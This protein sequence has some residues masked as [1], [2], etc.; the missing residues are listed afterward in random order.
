MAHWGPEDKLIR[1]FTKA[2]KKWGDNNANQQFCHK[3]WNKTRA[4][5]RAGKEPLSAVNVLDWRFGA[6]C[7]LRD[8]KFPTFCVV[9]INVCIY[10]KLAFDEEWVWRQ[11]GNCDSYQEFYYLTGRVEWVNPGFKERMYKQYGEW[12]EQISRDPV[13]SMATLS[14]NE[15]A[16]MRKMEDLADWIEKLKYDSERATILSERRKRERESKPKKTLREFTANL[17]GYS[18][19]LPDIE[20]VQKRGTRHVKFYEPS[21]KTAVSPDRRQSADDGRQPGKPNP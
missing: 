13:A 6:E 20:E 10:S 2:L 18:A 19:P 14:A 16:G 17:P 8:W 3:H 11:I 7:M 1:R 21:A 12:L 15:G 5:I 9:S 4:N